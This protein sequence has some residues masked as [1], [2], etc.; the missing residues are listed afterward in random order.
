MTDGDPAGDPHIGWI[1][2][3]SPGEHAT[4]HIAYVYEDGSVYLPEGPSVV[5][6]TD[7]R[8]ASATDRFWPLVRLA[9]D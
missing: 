2:F 8:L 5:T 1:E 3:V 9:D 7:F 6:E 4:T